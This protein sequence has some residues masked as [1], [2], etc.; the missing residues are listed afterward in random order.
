VSAP[1]SFGPANTFCGPLPNPI[2]V[3]IIAVCETKE[4]SLRVFFAE[5]HKK[6]QSLLI[7]QSTIVEELLEI[8]V[9]ALR[10]A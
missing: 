6:I 7:E 1:Y 5:N 10:V 2:M 8:G 9:V 3:T 4:W